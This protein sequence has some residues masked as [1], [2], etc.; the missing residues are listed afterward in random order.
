MIHRANFG[1]IERFLALLI[2]Q[3]GGRWPFWLSP[4]Q[5]IILTVNQDE[6]VVKQAHEAAANISGFKALAQ[7]P[8]DQG[9]PKPLSPVHSTFSIEVDASSQ[10]LGK[11]IQRAK[12]MK[13]NLVFI[14]GPKDLTESRITID[15]TGQMQSKADRD[16]QKLRGVLAEQLGEKALQNPRAIPIPV[17]SVHDLLVQLEKHFV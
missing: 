11:K 1:S 17:D 12:Q 13:Y 16:A 4:R 6:S 7:N 15:I 2:E 5:G 3:Y 14:L 9:I 10:T 8:T